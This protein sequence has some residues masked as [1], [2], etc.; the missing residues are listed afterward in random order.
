MIAEI[1]NLKQPKPIEYSKKI[2]VFGDD[3]FV[4]C[5][6]KESG[7]VLSSGYSIESKLLNDGNIMAPIMNMNSDT[8]TN[9]FNNEDEFSTIYQNLAIPAGLSYINYPSRKGQDPDL[10]EA[11]DRYTFK[12]TL[13]DDVFDRLFELIQ[14]PTKRSNNKSRKQE[15]MTLVGLDGGSSKKKR[16]YTRKNKQ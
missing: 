16:K 9:I 2:C 6:D 5:V 3:D 7:K 14:A 13:S 12:E 4:M 10:A 1:Y 8:D 15:P 11:S